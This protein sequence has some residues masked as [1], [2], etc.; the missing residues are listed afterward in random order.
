MEKENRKHIA[1]PEPKPVLPEVRF[2]IKVKAQHE[3][4]IADWTGDPGRTL[5]KRRART[6]VQ[7][8][9]AEKLCKKLNIEF[10]NRSMCVEVY[11]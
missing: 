2:C 1:Q 7:K 10:P 9:D 11:S 3:C 5:L 6:F 8:P 4:W